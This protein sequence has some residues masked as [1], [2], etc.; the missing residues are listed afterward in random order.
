MT[1][2]TQP[3]RKTPLIALD[4]G[5]ARIGVAISESWVIA[6]PVEPI[7]RK[8]LGRKGTLTAI[9]DLL[10]KYASTELLLGLPLLEC[11]EEGEQA[12]KTRA[13]A[14]SLLRRRP[15]ISI[16]FTDERY[17]SAEAKEIIGNRSV[18][19][20]RLDSVAAAV[21]LQEYLDHK[22]QTS[23]HTTHQ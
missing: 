17:S 5:E 18:P 1:S 21:F 3:A 14:R 13:F 4:V 12:E 7:D 19:K 23:K 16:Y 15:G 8:S 20:G 10:V 6:N 9:E 22:S 2:P 11:G